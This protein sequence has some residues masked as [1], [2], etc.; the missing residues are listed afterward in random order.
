MRVNFTGSSLRIALLP[1]FLLLS[2]MALTST[3]L[4]FR[5][6]PRSE[7]QSFKNADLVFEGE[8]V[9]ISEVDHRRVY[10]FAVS[11]VLKGTAD[12]EVIITDNGSSCDAYFRRDVVYRVYANWFEGK[13]M[14]GHCAGNKTLKVKKS[15]G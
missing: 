15:H 1:V 3:S 11:K 10:T 4:A 12:R 13:L 8:V 14:S 5:C 6:S 2:L 9:R 7:K